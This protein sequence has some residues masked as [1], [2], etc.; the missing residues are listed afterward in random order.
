MGLAI[1]ILIVVITCLFAG[2][3]VNVANKGIREFD[4]SKHESFLGK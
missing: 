3:I 4:E 1:G 2:W